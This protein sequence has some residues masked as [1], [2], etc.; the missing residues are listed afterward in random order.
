MDKNLEELKK[1]LSK[2]ALGYTYD[3]I[4]EEYSIT[5]EGEKLTKRKKTTKVVPPDISAAKLL[6][7]IMNE[8][9][10][11]YEN[12]TDEQLDKEIEKIKNLLESATGTVT[13]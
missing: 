4:I 8:N 11:S 5:E 6:L 3:E 10:N 13:S 7:E 12:L 9:Q 1:V 2:K